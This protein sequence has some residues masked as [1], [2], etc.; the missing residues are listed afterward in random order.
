M[1]NMLLTWCGMLALVGGA[2]LSAQSSVPQRPPSEKT[3]A[4]VATLTVT[5]C[6]ERWNPET[7]AR[8]GAPED[9][10]AGVE[11][12]L[13]HVEGQSPAAGA[14]KPAGRQIEKRYLL[15]PSRSLDYGAHR[16]HKVTISGTIAPQPAEGASEA[17]K[18][19]NPSTRETNLPVEPKAE[20]YHYNLVDVSSLTMV[21]RSCG[22]SGGSRIRR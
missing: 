2:G 3:M 10:P 17:D 6:L 4:G 21:S 12:V 8:T 7:M 20:A 16:G 15:L 19:T 14:A 1:R 11:Y 9:P 5:G 18:V 13:T 22:Q